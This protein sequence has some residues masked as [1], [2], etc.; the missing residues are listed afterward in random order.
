V[1]WADNTLAAGTAPLLR[2]N[3]PQ[4]AVKVSSEDLAD[5]ASGTGAAVLGFGG[6]ASAAKARQVACDADLRRYL[7]SADRELLDYGR[8]QRIVTPG[9]R[10]AVELRDETCVFAGCDAP[11]WW[12]EV[13][14]VI[15]WLFGGETNLANSALLCERH[16]TQVHHG[17][18]VERDPAGRW[19]TYRPD[20]TEIHIIRPAPVDEEA[21]S[22]AG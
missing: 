2:R 10:K 9:L 8:T 15:H 16:H 12:C 21:L 19:H 13:H 6:V 14:H 22:R 20:G 4:V 7:L 3:R 18:T 5:P 17:F 11:T 1:Q